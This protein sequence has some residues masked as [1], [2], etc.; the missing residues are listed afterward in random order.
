M[1]HSLLTP[2]TTVLKRQGIPLSRIHHLVRNGDMCDANLRST[3]GRDPE[4]DGINRMQKALGHDIAQL[5]DLRV[6]VDCCCIWRYDYPERVHAICTAIGGSPHTA[7]RL[8]YQVSPERRQ[9]LMDYAHALAGWLEGV[10]VDDQAY[11][12]PRAGDSA[13]R[14]YDML[15]APDRIKMLLVERTLYGLSSR[16]LNCSFWGYNDHEPQTALSPF[17]ARPLPPNWHSRMAALEQDIRRELGRSAGNFLCD[18]GGTAEPACHFK[19]IRRV[20]ILVSSIGC[21]T[22]RGN[23]PQKDGM[24]SGRRRLTQRYLRAL[25]RYWSETADDPCDAD[26]G[27]LAQTLAD[28]LGKPDAAKRWL[29]ASLW[30]NIKNQTMQHAYPMK[31][32]VEFVRIGEDYLSGT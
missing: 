16:A 31:R 14:V 17:A 32:W 9:E 4:V 13:R 30:K 27:A 1:E 7:L 18:V 3:Y 21:G 22:W 8:H 24:I 26:E 28:L 29:V 5:M 23:L 20:D 6:A 19:F 11:Y 15:G 2:R 10:A 25:A 12:G